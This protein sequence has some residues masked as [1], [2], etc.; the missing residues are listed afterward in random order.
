MKPW[1]RGKPGGVVAFLI[2]AALVAG[3]LGWAT[4]A[5]LRLEREQL[6]QR[7]EV[8]RANRLRLALWRLDSRVSPLLARE[9]SRPFDHYTAIFAVPLTFDN[10]GVCREPGTV[11]EPSPLLNIELPEWMRLHF[12]VDAETGWTSPQVPQ[13]S[14][15]S[16]LRNS[17]VQTPMENVTPQRQQLLSELQKNLPPLT[18][19]SCA[20]EHLQ[21]ATLHDKTLLITRLR[22]ENASQTGRGAMNNS[23]ENMPPSEFQ[24]RK[25]TQ[26]KVQNEGKNYQIVNSALALGNLKHNGEDWLSNT[27]PIAAS[28]EALVNLSPMAPLWVRGNNGRDCLLLARLVQIQ[29]K[30][31]CQGIVLDVEQLQDLLT[32][33]VGDLFPESH[34]LPVRGSEPAEPE[35]TMTTLPLQLEP[36]DG[37]V[38]LADPGWTTLRVGLASA[39]AAALIALGAVA[40]GGWS[41]IDLSQRRIRFVSAVTH[42]LRTP[43]TTLRLYLDM[44]TGGMVRDEKQRTEYLQTLHA[45]TDRLYRLVSQVLDFS[46]LENQR[47]RLSWSQVRIADL[48]LQVETT[49][50]GRCHDAEKELILENH[51]GESA[52]LCTDGSLLEQILG[53]LLDNACKYSRD[54]E[55]RR[56]WVRAAAAA[57]WMRF[58][59]EDRGPGISSSER[60]SIFRAFRRGHD[61]D[62]TAG[63]VGLGLALARRWV[64]L[65]G[66]RLTLRAQRPQAG[67]CF[68]IELPQRNPAF[69]S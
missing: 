67:A 54:A 44:L 13:P 43:L 26:Q 27:L 9:D 55:D 52:A 51:L 36:A 5:A 39:W 33:E 64:K 65:L 11:M 15:V 8:E 3:G 2:I 35:R 25:D 14:L 62:V 49:W 6:E 30:E 28:T 4:A 61:A 50:K 18:L 40:L 17:R 47:P 48:F 34:L 45:E 24:A 1:L 19:L 22:Q 41:L 63:G 23:L 31:I 58:E 7:A 16:K 66:G 56:V 46:R 20:R 38:L 42:E 29:G 32:E 37:N 60:R 10:N 57:G 59:V 12:Q 53:I 68:R 21:P 69:P